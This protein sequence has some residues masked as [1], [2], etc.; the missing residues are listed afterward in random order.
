MRAAGDA[1]SRA[2]GV[3]AGSGSEGYFIDAEGK[4]IEG[5]LRF[6]VKDY[7]SA[8]STDR[9][10]GF[11]SIEGTLLN[12]DDDAKVDA[13]ER[14]KAKGKGKGARRRVGGAGRNGVAA[15]AASSRRPS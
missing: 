9:E 11:L 13:E 8:P 7:E 4:K 10:R 14:A 3:G 2:R 6:R 1:G 15:A 5:L 12:D